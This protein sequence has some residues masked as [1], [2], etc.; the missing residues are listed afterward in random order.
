VFEKRAAPDPTPLLAPRSVAV[1]G[2]S[3]RAGSY[4]DNVLRNIATAGFGGSVWAINPRHEEVHGRPCLP[5]LLDLPEPVD[6][7]VIAIPAASVAPVLAEAIERGCGG[8]IVLSAGF[9][10]VEASAGLERE[11][12]AVALD[13]GLPLCGPNCNG[14]ISVRSR[15]PLWGDSVEELS[16]GGVALISQSG[17]LAVNA[18]GLRR[19]IG[20]H[21]VVSTG[22]QAVLDAS[23]WIDAVAGLDGVRSIAI[24]LEG[25]G[26]GASLARALA[27]CAE[28]EI[29]VAVL[30]VGSS[31]GG[32]RAAGAHT[33]ALAGDQRVFAALLEEAG[34]AEARDPQELLELGRCLAQAPPRP[35]ERAG[36]LAILTCSGGDSGLAADLAEEE[37]LELPGLAPRTCERLAGLLPSVATVGNPLDYTSMLWDDLDVLEQV[38]EAV[39]SDPGIDQLLLL[40]DMPAGLSATARPTWDAVRRALLAGAERGDAEPLLASTM[41]DLLDPESALELAERGI[42]ATAGLREAIRCVRALRAPRP[43]ASRLEEIAAATERARDGALAESGDGAGRGG[44]WLSEAEAKRLLAGAGVSVPRGGEVSDAD[45]AIAIAEEIDGPVAVKLSGPDLRHKSEAGAVAL[46]LEGAAEVGEACARLLSLPEADR[47]TLLVE[48]MVDGEVEVIVAARRDGVVP[49]VVVGL[50]GIWAEALADVAIVPLPASPGRVEE[51]LSGLRAAPILRGSR[52]GRPLDLFAA[53]EL[54][55]RLGDLLLEEGLDLIE[56]NPALLGRHGCVA[57]DAIA[58]R[59]ARPG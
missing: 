32:T 57:V 38:T 55:S 59:R 2:A 9:G 49:A 7:V 27:R 24:F 47:A 22:N 43:E 51:A 39:G 28:R 54:G 40:F 53:A 36:G 26:D 19:G 48:A 16:E 14:I 46:G 17:N 15:A 8:A 31:E 34:A 5:T 1:V 33:G 52:G 18:L 35:R 42:A 56:V 29:G 13:G 58:R 45:A 21:T 44:D 23:D 4:G 30:K 3:E 10:E 50:G 41:P 25:D 20:F 12:A 6:A 11:L 37:G